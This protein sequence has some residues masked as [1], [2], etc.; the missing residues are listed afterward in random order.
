MEDNQNKQCRNCLK[1]LHVSRFYKTKSK[2]YPD[3]LIN[4]CKVCISLYRK[5]KRIKV[6]K[7]S[8]KIEDREL[9]MDFD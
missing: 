1:D 6:I 4:W 8:F 2:S 9:T 5:E 7:P 3:S